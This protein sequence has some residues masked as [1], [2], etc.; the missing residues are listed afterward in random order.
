MSKAAARLLIAGVAAFALTSCGLFSD[1]KSESPKS[2]GE[3]G[4]PAGGVTVTYLIPASQAKLGNLDKVI[5]AWE[6]KTGNKIDLQA[7]ADQYESVVSTRLQSGTGVDIFQGKYS[8]FDVPAQMHPISNTDFMSRINPTLA[9]AMKFDGTVYGIPVP[10][11]INTMGVF[12][13]K[14]AFAKAGVTEPPKTLDEMTAAMAKLK[15]ADINPLFFSGAGGDGWTLLQDRNALYF[16]IGYKSS[17]IWDKLN[18]NEIKWP[19]IPEFTDHF[20]ALAD[21]VKNGY[22]NPDAV[23]ANYSDAQTAV[24]TG[25][26]AMVIQGDWV[27]G[28]ILKVSPDAKI[29]FFPLPTKSGPAALGI[30]SGDGGVHIAKSSKVA[31][32]AEDFLRFRIEPE[33]VKLALQATP[34]VSAF[35]DVEVGDLLPDALK[36][37][38]DL[39]KSGPTTDKGETSYLVPAP[40]TDLQG[41]YQE[42]LAGRMDA[43]TFIAQWQTQYE[44]AAKTAGLAG[45]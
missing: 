37:I 32:A 40:E 17:G 1:G 5:A 23:T 8:L 13:N 45:F 9:E 33:Q 34:A 20:Q 19:D 16:D 3:S 35:N 14:D 15:T 27:V 10:T 21:W 22:I 7:I 18:K 4:K 25:K 12:Y 6:A 41:L 24:G 2:P 36:T 42:L 30:S 28:E 11:G 29:G 31:A 39:T 26:S 44:K 38:T 43:A